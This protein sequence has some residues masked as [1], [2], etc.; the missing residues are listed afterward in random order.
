MSR[1]SPQQIGKVGERLFYKLLVLG[2]GGK[3]EAYNPVAD[4]ERRDFEVHIKGEYRPILAIQVKC[5]ARLWYDNRKGLARL[6]ISFQVPEGNLRT[7]RLFWYFFACLDV[8]SMGFMDPAF[9]VPSAE[10]HKHA[11]LGRLHGN[12]VD[13]DFVANMAHRSRDRWAPYRV[14]ALD[15]GKRVLQIIRDSSSKSMKAA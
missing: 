14:P 1:L 13:F 11:R 5:A 12:Q 9:I 15:V 2:S 7:D 8:D 10:I 4:E 3:L 6:S